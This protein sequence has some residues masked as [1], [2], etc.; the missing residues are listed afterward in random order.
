MDDSAIMYD[1][2]RESYDKETKNIPA[3]FNEKKAICKKQNFY[4]LLELLLITI[5]L[6]TDARIL[7]LFDKILN[8]TETFITISRQK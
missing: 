6:L 8:N 5:T 1:E 2:V 7:L 4:I 3:N